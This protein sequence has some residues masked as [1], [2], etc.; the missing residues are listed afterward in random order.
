MG[1]SKFSKNIVIPY[2]PENRNRTSFPEKTPRDSESFDLRE[3][4]RKSRVEII[5][6]NFS[7]T[8]VGVTAMKTRLSE[9][10][11]L[12]I[13]QVVRAHFAILRP[14]I[15]LHMSLTGPSG[16]GKSY[17]ARKLG[18]LLW[19]LG[20]LEKGHLVHVTRYELIG[21]FVG[22]T[23]P[24]THKCLLSAIGGVF[25]VDDAYYLVKA[26]N[27]VDYGRESIEMILQFLENNRGLFVAIFAGFADKMKL[28]YSMNPGLASRVLNHITFDHFTGAE[29]EELLD[30]E[31][32]S[33]MYKMTPE[34]RAEAL[35]I[36]EEKRKTPRL[37]GNARTVKALVCQSRLSH[38]RRLVREGRSLTSGDLWT[39][40]QSDVKDTE[41]VV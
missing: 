38:S 13:M 30:H 26:E 25:F 24:K 20:Y 34:A 22:S 41:K 14:P 11:T 28:F 35:A 17:V 7:R 29:L 5:L 6:T 40:K 37:W 33:A 31:L 1:I 21:Q 27:S 36:F 15:G 16:T 2:T 4:Y 32:H 10:A 9:L 18:K 19:G 8:L 23:A 12:S 39:I 3:A